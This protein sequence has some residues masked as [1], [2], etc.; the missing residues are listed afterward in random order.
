MSLKGKNCELYVAMAT[1]LFQSLSSK[2]M[3]CS[4]QIDAINSQQLVSFL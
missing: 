3:S 4:L 1:L 2:L